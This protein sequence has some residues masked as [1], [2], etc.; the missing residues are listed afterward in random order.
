MIIAIK[1]I[2]ATENMKHI[3]ISIK[4]KDTQNYDNLL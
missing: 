2:S 1:I 3:L 4:I